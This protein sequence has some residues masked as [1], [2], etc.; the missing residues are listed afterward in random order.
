MTLSWFWFCLVIDTL[1]FQMDTQ[2]LLWKTS[3]RLDVQFSFYDQYWQCVYLICPLIGLKILGFFFSALNTLSAYNRVQT[4][5]FSSYV[6]IHFQPCEGQL[7]SA[8]TPPQ[9][10]M[11]KERKSRKGRKEVFRLVLF[12]CLVVS[13]TISY[14]NKVCCCSK[15]QPLQQIFYMKWVC[16]YF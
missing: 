7:K 5:R 12:H 10:F 3:S 2:F 9:H 6:R 4:L 15:E 8:P 14:K 11:K 13:N 16:E 1:I